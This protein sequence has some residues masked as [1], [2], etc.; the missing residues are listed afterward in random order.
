MRKLLKDSARKAMMAK[1]ANGENYCKK[2][3]VKYRK[4]MRF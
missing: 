1:L 2:C 4:G 3:N